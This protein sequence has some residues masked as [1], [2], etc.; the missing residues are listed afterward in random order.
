MGDDWQQIFHDSDEDPSCLE[1]SLVKQPEMA[2]RVDL[3]LR[4]VNVDRT[5]SNSTSSCP[6]EER[7]HNRG[8]KSASFCFFESFDSQKQPETAQKVN[9][10]LRDVNPDINESKSSSSCGGKSVER[11]LE[12]G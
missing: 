4:Y 11:G 1:S 2:Q 9:L 5:E 8:T 12:V 7:K 3:M 10:R 6:G